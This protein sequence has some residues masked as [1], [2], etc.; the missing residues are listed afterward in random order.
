MRFTDANCAGISVILYAITA[1][2]MIS[3]AESQEKCLPRA[4]KQHSV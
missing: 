2:V 4:L 3:D 1:S